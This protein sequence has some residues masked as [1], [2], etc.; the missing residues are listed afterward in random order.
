MKPRPLS[1]KG[2]PLGWGGFDVARSLQAGA[3]RSPS[4]EPRSRR[5]GAVCSTHRAARTRE[6][7]S[8]QPA[9]WSPAWS[10]A[11]RRPDAQEDKPG[12]TAAEPDATGAAANDEP[13]GHQRQQ[14]SW[15]CRLSPCRERDTLRVC[16]ACPGSPKRSP[17]S[18]QPGSVLASTPQEGR[19]RPASPAAGRRELGLGGSGKKMEGRSVVPRGVL[20][21]NS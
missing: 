17:S 1:S 5:Q 3:H 19:H 15:L 8:N 7:G 4:P 21:M 9:V 14:Q 2:P 16:P 11:G 12:G 10:P 6:R 20:A 18:D 13:G